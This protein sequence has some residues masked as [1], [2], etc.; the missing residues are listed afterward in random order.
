MEVLHQYGHAVANV[1]HPGEQGLVAI[2]GVFVDTIIV[3]TF[4]A[5]IILLTGANFEGLD[6]ATVTQKG[7]EIAFGHTGV[8]Y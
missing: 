8:V 5:L 1:K 4:T 7:F 3:C 2:V 6:G